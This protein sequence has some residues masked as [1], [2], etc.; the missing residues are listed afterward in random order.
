MA[1][2]LDS[3]EKLFRTNEEKEA[4]IFLRG[5]MYERM[6]NYTAAEDGVPQSAGHQSRQ[7]RRR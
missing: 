2:M 4:V 3:A 1:K 5:A 6:K 7:R